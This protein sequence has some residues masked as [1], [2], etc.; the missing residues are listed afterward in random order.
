MSIK[1]IQ[2]AL[3]YQRIIIQENLQYFKANHR[4]KQKTFASEITSSL[5][6]TPKFINPK[7]FYDEIGSK[8]FDEICGLPEYYPYVCELS[9]LKNIGNESV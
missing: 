6:S 3:D 9:I 7:Y 1:Y 4:I 2:K 8:L 5:Q